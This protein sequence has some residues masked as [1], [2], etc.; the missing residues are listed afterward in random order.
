MTY[1]EISIFLAT[2]IIGAFAMFFV[3]LHAVGLI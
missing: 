2:G 1:R 3:S